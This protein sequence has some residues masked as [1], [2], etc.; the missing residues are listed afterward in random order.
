MSSS[1]YAVVHICAGHINFSS[2]KVFYFLLLC[3]F[4]GVFGSW[5]FGGYGRY[6]IMGMHP[7]VALSKPN[8]FI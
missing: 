2:S 7:T 1:I 3:F 8:W 4:L 6:D 5:G